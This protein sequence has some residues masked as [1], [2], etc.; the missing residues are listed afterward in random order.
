MRR[1]NQTRGGHPRSPARWQ[2]DFGQWVS[3]FGVSRIV[4]ALA[5]D[6]DLRVTSRAVYQWLRGHSPHPTRA[7]ALVEISGGNLSL[8]SIY[9]HRSE[10][11]KEKQEDGSTGAQG[12]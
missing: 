4:D 9:R 11:G 6:P 5:H 8:E 1:R 10:I 7:M 12:S 2:T 3:D